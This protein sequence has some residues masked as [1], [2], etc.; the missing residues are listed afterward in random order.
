LDVFPFIAQRELLE[1][2]SPINVAID[3][4]AYPGVPLITPTDREREDGV[5]EGM[6]EMF[7][8]VSCY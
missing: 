7:F 8:N 6:N 5:G 2:E 3:L 4:V 1:K